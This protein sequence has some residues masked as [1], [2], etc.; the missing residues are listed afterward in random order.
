MTNLGV[1]IGGLRLKNPVIAA[2]GEHLQTASG[3][4]AALRQGAAVVVAK[5]INE[6]SAAKLQLEQAEYLLLDENWNSQGWDFTPPVP[7]FMLS[8]SGLID[9][10]IDDWA[11]ELGRLDL[12]A[13]QNDAYVAASIVLADLDSAVLMAKRFARAGIRL[14]EFNIGTPYG[15]EASAV[16]T[17]RSVARVNALVTTMRRAVPDT[18]LWIKLTGQSENVAALAHAARDAGADSVVLIGRPLGML[19]DLE[20]MT[21]ML[22]TNAA[23]GGRWALPLTCYW[24]AR[25]RKTL[26]QHYP[27]I[28]TNGARDGL[29]VAR[30]LLAGASAVEMCSAVLAGGFGVIGTSVADLAAYLGRKETNASAII[31]RAADANKGF[32]DLPKTGSWRS[33]V[34]PETLRSSI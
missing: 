22:G 17:E 3:I 25:T 10:S 34:P 15:D 27:I 21:P 30:M 14:L 13:R 9:R 19:P 1:H 6:T 4:R 23:F 16:T 12:E 11:E 2:A 26:G 28:G 5:S 18:A 8:R 29:D 33:H 31:G 7:A 24:L 20:S 32:A